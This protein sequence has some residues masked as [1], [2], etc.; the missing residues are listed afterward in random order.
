[1]SKINPS[2]IR[3]PRGHKIEVKEVRK[4]VYAFQNTYV[5]DYEYFDRRDGRVKSDAAS[6]SHA[7][8]RTASSKK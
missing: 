3:H 4:G 7:E 8:Q 1:M 2:G 5:G 6:Q